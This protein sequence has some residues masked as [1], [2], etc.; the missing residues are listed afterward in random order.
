MSILCRGIAA[1]FHLTIK[2]LHKKLNSD[3]HGHCHLFCNAGLCLNACIWF[4]THN[5]PVPF[6][7][8]TLMRWIKSILHCW[9]PSRQFRTV[10]SAGQL[11]LLCDHRETFVVMLL[12]AV[13][14]VKRHSSSVST[15]WQKLVWWE[16][17]FS[18]RNN[19]FGKMPWVLFLEKWNCISATEI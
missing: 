7:C 8:R 13:T 18:M 12:V 10:Q 17:T 9:R 6:W 2:D 19:N 14:E 1:V 3:G 15:L 4:S 16:I 5:R 11:F